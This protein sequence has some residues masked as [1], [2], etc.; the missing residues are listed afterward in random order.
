LLFWFLETPPLPVT[1]SL[2]LEK[3]KGQPRER[4]GF[5]KRKEKAEERARREK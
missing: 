3:L 1:F 5:Q 2:S 4:E